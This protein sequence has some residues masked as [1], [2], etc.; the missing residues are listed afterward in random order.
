MNPA[1]AKIQS[2]AD[3]EALFQQ[4]QA[5]EAESNARAQ[6]GSEKQRR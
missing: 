2:D 3:K 6:V 5:W 1:A 4:F